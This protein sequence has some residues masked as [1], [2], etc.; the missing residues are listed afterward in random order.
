MLHNFS[1]TLEVKRS[2]VN[3]LKWVNSRFSLN[4]PFFK[5]SLFAQKYGSNEDVWHTRQ[6]FQPSAATCKKPQVDIIDGVSIGAVCYRSIK[7][8]SDEKLRFSEKLRYF[9]WKNS[10]HSIQWS[11]FLKCS[12]ITKFWHNKWT[13]C[14]LHWK[15]N[16]GNIL[17]SLQIVAV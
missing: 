13:A 3:V 2:S 14:T 12:N 8:E 7:I 17:N 15:K 6:N 1:A 10:L 4:R 5:S 16:Y 11:V 9:P